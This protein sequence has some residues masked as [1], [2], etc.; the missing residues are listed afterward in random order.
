MKSGYSPEIIVL[1]HVCAAEISE[2]KKLQLTHFLTQNQLN[3][4]RL[5]TLANWHRLTP[6]LY[7]M[8]QTIPETPE[9]FLLKLRND[10]Q[11]S[12]IDTLLKQREYH[13]V[14]ELLS[15]QGIEHITYK[16]VYLAEH[17]YPTS[18]L[19]ICGDI[20]IL[21]ATEDAPKA[22]RLLQSHQYHLNQLH[23][24][25][26][27]H[28]EYSLLDDLPEVS[29]FKPFVG[30][31]SQFDIDLHW[32]IVCFNKHYKSFKMSD[33]QAHPDF[34]AELQVV[35]LVTHHGVTDLWQRIFYINDLYFLLNDQTIDWT[36][37]LQKLQSYGLEKTFLV[38]LHWCQ[39][40]W[41]LPLPPFVQALLNASDV[42]S[43][44]GAYEKNWEVSHSMKDSNLVVTQ[45]KFFT[46]AQTQVGKLVKIYFTFFT[47]R[48]FRAST[49][50]FGEHL[51]YI[52]QELGLITIF[53]RATR[54]IYNFL[55]FNFSGSEANLAKEPGK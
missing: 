40:I 36:W 7:Q 2:N 20:D 39:Q 32:S 13:Q 5:Y 54:S 53:I 17:F 34:F 16:G 6:F 46:K 22:I 9:S 8:L 18:S 48:V 28:N 11:H 19:R 12:A 3:W 38:G 10:C 21:V 35:L 26:W 33:F 42:R 27:R 24:R 43:I 49:F 30:M 51:L 15:N 47:S 4:D 14:T 55:L 23:T 41:D 52:P 25:F 37:L 45:L 44:A 1:L 50:R 31:G 29:L